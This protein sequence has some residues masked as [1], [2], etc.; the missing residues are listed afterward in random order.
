MSD[1]GF[2]L[3]NLSVGKSKLYFR[4]WISKLIYETRNFFHKVKLSELWLGFSRILNNTYIYE[5]NK[6]TFTPPHHKHHI[7]PRYAHDCFNLKSAY[8]LNI[9]RFTHRIIFLCIF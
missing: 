8:Y 6:N 1:N 5:N 9:L 7:L 4:S 2:G 3:G